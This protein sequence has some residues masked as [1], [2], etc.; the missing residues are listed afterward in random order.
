MKH[1]QRNLMNNLQARFLACAVALLLT[2][3]DKP[4]STSKI[5]APTP[6]AQ[7]PRGWDIPTDP[8][9]KAAY[10][11]AHSLKLP[12]S[13]PKPVPFNFA[14]AERKARMKD[15][16][17]VSEQYFEHLCK[18]EA[19][20]Y[21]FKTVENVEGVFQMRPRPKIDDTDIDFDRYRLEEPTGIGWSGDENNFNNYGSAEY[22][23][24]PMIGRYQYLEQPKLGDPKITFRLVRGVNNDPPPGEQNGHQTA[25]SVRGMPMYLTVPWVAVMEESNKRSARYGFTWRGIKYDRDRDLA[26]GG[27]E[28]LVV[29]LKTSEI[30]AMKRMFKISGHDKRRQSG[31]AWSNARPC[32]IDILRRERLTPGIVPIHQFINRVLIPNSTINDQYIS[33]DYRNALKGETK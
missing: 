1:P 5:A 27:G 24:Q 25:I 13:V 14:E 8:Q 33:E 30:L 7:A 11:Y 15:G 18:T 21:I 31:I 32:E 6:A 20:E 28:Y 3:C 16:K 29:D 26:I 19:G 22:Y 4:T 10:D 17:D 12:D 2:A 23:V 9:E